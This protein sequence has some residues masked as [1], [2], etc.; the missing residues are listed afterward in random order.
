MSSEKV[1]RK[2]MKSLD[3]ALA[4]RVKQLRDDLGL[5]QI[6]FASLLRVTRTQVWEWERGIK[7]K[8][9]IEKIIEMASLAPSIENRIW[10]WEKAGVNLDVIKAD[11]REQLRTRAGERDPDKTI[12]IPVF[13]NLTKSPHGKLEYIADG[14]IALPSDLIDHPGSVACFAPERRRP[15]ITRDDDLVLIDRSLTQPKDLWEKLSAVFFS[16]LPITNEAMMGAVPMPLGFIARPRPAFIDPKR[17]TNYRAVT[18]FLYP[19]GESPSEPQKRYAQLIEEASGPGFLVGW[20]H[21]ILAGDDVDL[22]FDTSDSPPWRLALTVQS[23][24]SS[25]CPRVALSDWRYTHMPDTE[26]L[27][28]SQV[29]LLPGIEILGQVVGWLGKEGS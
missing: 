22:E 29:P 12:E 9:S 4:L 19:R 2:P 21:V 1:V 20:L 28:V 3:P 23:P 14:N 17:P 13:R 18:D 27:T 8:P 11:F 15:W 6:E 7:E 24:L 5:S 26:Y 10:F 16:S 25:F